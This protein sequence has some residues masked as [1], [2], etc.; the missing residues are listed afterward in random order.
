MESA[1]KEDIPENEAQLQAATVE[2]MTFDELSDTIKDENLNME[3]FIAKTLEMA[4]TVSDEEWR[5]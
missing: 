1:K 2:F 5:P 4:S 3:E